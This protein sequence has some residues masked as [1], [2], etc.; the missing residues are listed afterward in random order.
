MSKKM[1]K[2]QNGAEG[3]SEKIYALA[4]DLTTM[5]QDESVEVSQMEHTE[6]ELRKAIHSVLTYEK[7]QEL[8]AAFN[9]A[10][11]NEE[12]DVFYCIRDI[13]FNESQ[14][15][16]HED[17]SVSRLV[18]I[19]LTQI[20][21]AAQKPKRNPTFKQLQEMIRLA[22]LEEEYI[23]TKENFF[24][25]NIAMTMHEAQTETISGWHNLLSIIALESENPEMKMG[26][27]LPFPE[28]AN[29]FEILYL[30]GIIK[31][32]PDEYLP[33]IDEIDSEEMSA[34][35]LKVLAQYVGTELNDKYASQMCSWDFMPPMPFD[36]GLD[37]S[38]RIRDDNIIR[39]LFETFA[40]RNDLHFTLFKVEGMDNEMALC[41]LDDEQIQTICML[42]D[43]TSTMGHEEMFDYMLQQINFYEI[44]KLYIMEELVNLNVFESEY[45]RVSHFLLNESY[46]LENTE[47]AERSYMH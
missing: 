44:D 29:N 26:K 7:E 30:T 15:Y 46:E 16:L 43:L 9:K 3:T 13:S 40:G 45:F 35:Y 22:L 18:L 1:S 39:C 32:R 24:L 42:S 23:F 17:G 41:I 19:P 8:D 31:S 10:V 27:T 36:R 20:Y 5:E 21:P 6:N 11:A 12:H 37:N 47:K 2:N 14:T 25:S 38:V 34:D 4:K 28:A 33:I